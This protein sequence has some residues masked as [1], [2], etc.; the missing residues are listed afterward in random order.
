MPLTVK[1]PNLASLVTDCCHPLWNQQW[2]S[3]AASTI[4]NAGLQ[5]IVTP[6][7][8]DNACV[9]LTS[10]ARILW[11]LLGSILV[12]ESPLRELLEHLSK[13]SYQDTK[14]LGYI[15]SISI[16]HWLKVTPG[17]VISSALLACLAH[18][19][20]SPGT[21]KAP[22][23][24]DAEAWRKKALVCAKQQ[25]CAKGVESKAQSFCFSWQKETQLH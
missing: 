25:K 1:C 11:V 20:A 24:R 15:L 5:R 14:K 22:R 8:L 12:G 3:R 10:G 18:C 6:E 17:D 21:R 9:I 23:Q 2:S 16:S 13:M 19:R 7:L 4:I